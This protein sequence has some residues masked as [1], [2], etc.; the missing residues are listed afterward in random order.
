MAVEREARWAREREAAAQAA[1]ETAQAAREAAE[2]AVAERAVA[3]LLAG[4]AVQVAAGLA[5]VRKV[6]IETS[7]LNFSLK[8]RTFHRTC[9]RSAHRQLV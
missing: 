9:T 4:V 1:R 6:D 2:R 5:M 8:N 7:K 3:E